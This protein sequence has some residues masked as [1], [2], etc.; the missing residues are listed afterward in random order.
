MK[1]LFRPRNLLILLG[2]GVIVGVVLSKKNTAPA[3]TY[4][5]PWAAPSPT[6]PTASSSSSSSSAASS[7]SSNGADS[8]PATTSP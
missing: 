4:P 3:P 5:D 1:K 2:I 6:S 7:S 8:E